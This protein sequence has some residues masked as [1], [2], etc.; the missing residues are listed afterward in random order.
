MGSS[1][2]VADAAL[3]SALFSRADDA[4]W[5]NGFDGAC[6]VVEV[7]T[8]ACY[9]NGTMWQSDGYANYKCSTTICI[10]PIQPN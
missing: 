10:D 6:S 9:F 2:A 5:N 4:C 1:C 3:T 7:V 8:T